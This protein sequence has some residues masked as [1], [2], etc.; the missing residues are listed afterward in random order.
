[1]VEQYYGM[2]GGYGYGFGFGWILTIL[3]WAF[4]IW[5]VLALVNGVSKQGC[6]GKHHH[7]HDAHK[8]EGDKVL[9]ILKERYVKGE[10]SKEDFDRM[11]QDI[12]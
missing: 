5:V 6:C 9:D 7:E 2:G 4:V 3:F 11:K 8:P 1:M 12:A 10:I